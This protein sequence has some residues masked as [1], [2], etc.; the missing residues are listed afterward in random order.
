MFSGNSKCRSWASKPLVSFPVVSA[1]FSL[2]A[3]IF[4]TELDNISENKS[5]AHPGCL[6]TFSNSLMCSDEKI[7]ESS[8]FFIQ[9]IHFPQPGDSFSTRWFLFFKQRI[10]FLQTEDL[11]TEDLWINRLLSC[12]SSFFENASYISVCC[13]SLAHKWRFCEPITALRTPGKSDICSLLM[14]VKV[15]MAFAIALWLQEK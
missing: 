13:K 3:S 14:L 7:C 8:V 1:H 5:D 11:Q 9:M 4:Q 12:N 6:H 10:H 2:L 15:E